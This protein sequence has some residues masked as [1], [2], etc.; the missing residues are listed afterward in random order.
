MPSKK[1]SQSTGQRHVMT[2]LVLYEHNYLFK[3]LQINWREERIRE[4][5]DVAVFGLPGH[6]GVLRIIV[7]LFGEPV[8]V[9]PC[10]GL[11]HP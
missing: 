3:F 2:P 11:F 10:F 8:L 4:T 9:H 1:Q 6:F 5:F 7:E